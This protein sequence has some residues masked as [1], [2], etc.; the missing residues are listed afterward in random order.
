MLRYTSQQT[1]AVLSG[2][3]PQTELIFYSLGNGEVVDTAEKFKISYD[4]PSIVS[5]IFKAIYK[6]LCLTLFVQ[7]HP[8][9]QLPNRG[10]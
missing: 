2:N 3:L 4:F 1:I 6:R 10:K 8:A 5:R 9:H 7:A